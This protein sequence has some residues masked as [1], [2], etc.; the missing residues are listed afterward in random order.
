[1]W[2]PGG[3]STWHEAHN[4]A[5]ATRTGTTWALAEGEVGGARGTETYILVANTSAYAGSATVTLLLENGTSATRTYALPANSRTNVPVGPDFGSP[6]QG[7]RFGAVVE[8]TGTTPAQIVVERAMYWNAGN[9]AW[10]AGTN[11]LATKLP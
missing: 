2:W 8:S 11:A 1:M 7:Q 4:S 3:Y 6:V 10:A 5:G 9:V